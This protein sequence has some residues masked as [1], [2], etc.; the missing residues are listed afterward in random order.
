[1][2]NIIAKNEDV[3]TLCIRI[4]MTTDFIQHYQPFGSR[5]TVFK[6]E[7]TLAFTLAPTLAIS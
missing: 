7:D 6:N 2:C 4:V 5:R 3:T 1:M